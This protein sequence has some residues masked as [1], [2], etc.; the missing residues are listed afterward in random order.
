MT[1]FLS[2]VCFKRNWL[3]ADIWNEQFVNYKNSNN[4]NNNNRFTAAAPS[5]LVLAPT[6][7]LA[8]QIDIECE[9]LCNGKSNVSSCVV[10]GGANARGQLVNL[11]K[12]K[13]IFSYKYEYFKID[14]YE[15]HPH[16]RAEVVV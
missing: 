8:I 2:A 7:E 13:D 9:K 14:G 4:N 1:I 16:I 11:A 6:R 10:Y 15:A 12:G 5:A 3:F